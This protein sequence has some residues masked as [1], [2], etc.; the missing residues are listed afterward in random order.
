MNHYCT[1]RL[2]IDDLAGWR[3]SS[4]PD[5]SWCREELSLFGKIVERDAW[6]N[7]LRPGPWLGK[8]ILIHIG[9]EEDLLGLFRVHHQHFADEEGEPTAEGFSEKYCGYLRYQPSDSQE[10]VENSIHVFIVVPREKFDTLV[11]LALHNL[12]SGRGIGAEMVLRGKALDR[13]KPMGTGMVAW[14]VSLGDLSLE[15][16]MRLLLE[17]F[18]FFDA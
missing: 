4:Q 1:I 7:Q 9:T 11:N 14:G 10:N 13:L 3:V 12:H 18:R 16:E 5:F 8:S 17:E 15:K 6:L 2:I